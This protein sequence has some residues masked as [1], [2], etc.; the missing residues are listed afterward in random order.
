MAVP[1]GGM[2]GILDPSGNVSQR[3]QQWEPKRVF[4]RSGDIH[5]NFAYSALACF[6]IG[7]SGSASFRTFRAAHCGSPTFRT[8]SDRHSFGIP[9]NNSFSRFDDDL[10]ISS[11]VAF[12]R[13]AGFKILP[14][15]ILNSGLL[16]VAADLTRASG[17]AFGKIPNDRVKWLKIWVGRRETDVVTITRVVLPRD[18]VWTSLVQ[19]GICASVDLIIGASIGFDVY[20]VIARRRRCGNDSVRV[21]PGGEGHLNHQETDNSVPI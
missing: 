21:S 15:H 7:M 19:S 1:L 8:S 3:N 5:C 11:I 4:K 16:R 13:S 14:N 18:R 17:C 2:R 12:K 9:R 20:C 10:G 6:R